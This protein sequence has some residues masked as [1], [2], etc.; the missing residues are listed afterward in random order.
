[1][2]CR[3]WIL[4]I[5][6]HYVTLD[7]SVPAIPG[8]FV[9]ESGDSLDMSSGRASDNTADAALLPAL[10][11]VSVVVSQP[12]LDL[13][14]QLAVTRKAALRGAPVLSRLPRATLDPASPSEDPH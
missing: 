9:F 13:R 10:A 2:N 8:A 6:L 7:L 11:G 4:L 3:R 5:V 12:P 14:G 1:M